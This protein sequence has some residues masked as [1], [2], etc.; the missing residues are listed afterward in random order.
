MH[1]S[2]DQLGFFQRLSRTPDGAALVVIYQAE[3]QE[4]DA[5]LRKATG[6]EIYRLQ[7]RAQQLEQAIE[8]LSSRST[9]APA[10]PSPVRLAPGR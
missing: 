3:L 2:N 7:G 5:K 4:T 1:L 10:R 6:E 8:Q 9:A